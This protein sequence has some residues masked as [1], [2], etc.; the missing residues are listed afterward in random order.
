[1]GIFIMSSIW[2]HQIYYMF[3]FLVLVLLILIVTCAE[4]SIA[5]TYFQLTTEVYRW[6][7]RSFLTSGSSAV[8]VF[9]YSCLYFNARLQ[10][11]KVVSMMLYFGYMFLV[12]FSFFLLSGTIGLVAS[13][14]FARA[15]YGSIKID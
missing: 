13:F 5:L 3:G 15:I 11:V 6:W 14:I 7:W 4:M 2:Q 1:M 9:L 10:I 12:A 8:Y